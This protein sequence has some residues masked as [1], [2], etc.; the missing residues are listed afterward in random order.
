MELYARTV[1]DEGNEVVMRIIASKGER[2]GLKLQNHTPLR[3]L[4]VTIVGEGNLSF[5]LRVSVEPEG[6]LIYGVGAIRTFRLGLL[7]PA[8]QRRLQDATEAILTWIVDSME[9]E[10]EEWIGKDY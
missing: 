10:A 8:V 6:A 4:F 5:F 1:N 2:I 7:R 3:F 9:K